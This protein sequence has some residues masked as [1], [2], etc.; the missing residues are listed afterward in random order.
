MNIE[1]LIVQKFKELGLKTSSNSNDVLGTNFSIYNLLDLDPNHLG[2]SSVKTGVES[3][4]LSFNCYGTKKGIA[5]NEAR[6]VTAAIEA[7]PQISANVNTSVV[8][9]IQS[10]PVMDGLF[11]YTLMATIVYFNT[12]Q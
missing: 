6:A 7:F 1:E 3:A 12:L 10:L 4:T 11:G 8:Y 9:G 2:S 5:Y